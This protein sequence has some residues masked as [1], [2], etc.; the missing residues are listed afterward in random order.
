MTFVRS[1]IIKC[2]GIHFLPPLDFNFFLLEKRLFNSHCNIYIYIIFIFISSFLATFRNK[3]L[4]FHRNQ[5]TGNKQPLV[6]LNIW[7]MVVAWSILIFI[8][9]SYVTNGSKLVPEFHLSS[10]SKLE[11]DIIHVWSPIHHGWTVQFA[12]ADPE[13]FW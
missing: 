4:K 9:E 7:Y 3:I 1:V 8:Y 11:H 10:R 13:I 5:I 6:N 2:L 12:F